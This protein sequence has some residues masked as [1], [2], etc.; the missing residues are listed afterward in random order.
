MKIPINEFEQHVD[1]DI[2][3]RGLQYF[4]KG[5]VSQVEELSGGEY[6]AVV[7]GSETYIVNLTLQHGVITDQACTCPYD[8]GP[9]CKHE[10]AVM[11]YLQQ[12]E[13]G[14]TVN[15]K[16]KEVS[17]TGTLKKKP[18]KKKTQ[19]EKVDE[20]LE[21]LSPDAVKE[22]IREYCQKNH[23]FR[24]LFLAKYLYLVHP[25]SKE[26][27]T[28]QIKAIINSVAGDFGYID[29]AAARKVGSAVNDLSLS[30]HKEIENGNYRV[31]M[32]MGCAILEE[33]TKAIEFG[34]D[35]NGDFGSG[36][37]QA[38]DILL[39]ITERPIDESL[40]KELFD[41]CVQAFVN[42]KFK[43]W[44]WHYTM[45]ELAIE[46][47][48]DEKEKQHIAM[49]L[50]SIKPSGEKWDY[51]FEKALQMKLELI[52]KTE[53]EENLQL[54]L[55]ANLANSNFRR[56]VLLGA[57]ARKDYNRAIELAKAGIVQDEKDKPGLADEWHWHLLQ[58][59]QQQNDT[60]NIIQQARYLFLN[61]SRWATKEMYEI[62]KKK[63]VASEWNAFFDQL[64]DDKK[65]SGRGLVFNNIA[66]MYVWEQ[67]WENL[68]SLLVKYPT[69]E[70]ISGYEKY[71]TPNYTSQVLD[72]YQS[73]I[74]AYL[75]RHVSRDYYQQACK[76]I[77]RMIK[78]GGREEAAMV[79]K[80]LRTLYP[81]RRAL[82]EEL[83]K[84]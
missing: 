81:Q 53:S 24:D 42:E 78:M 62:L 14:L 63:I 1:E 18:V 28:K 16:K 51:N 17:E 83:G 34:D 23:S 31:A 25:V 73:G 5:Y 33:M 71:L 6:E 64:V 9:V 79:V 37:E 32:Y 19:A 50:D 46:I 35:S 82:M 56:E 36:I 59:Y 69:L 60:Q 21:M 44:D 11:F 4:K 61:S 40:R 43:G 70:N 49:A 57:V 84:I 72:L 74:L 39:L 22:Y 3:K 15:P 20:L 45:L 55:E 52:R 77:R 12:E 26:L 13:L 75:K 8:W 2:L 27:Y 10:V 67:Q 65:K 7:D 41:Y 29:Y 66:E 76:Y 54:F 47:I 68:M 58:I 30:A 38:Q 48:K 80:N